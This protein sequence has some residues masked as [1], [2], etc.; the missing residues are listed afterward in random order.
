MVIKLY[1]IDNLMLRKR[2]I[3]LR[4]FKLINKSIQITTCFT[5]VELTN[6]NAKSQASAVVNCY[7]R[8]L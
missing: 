7:D 2:M 4:V 8:N 6:M 3:F 1:F 5:W